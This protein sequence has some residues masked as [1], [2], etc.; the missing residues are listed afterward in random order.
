MNDIVRIYMGQ[1]GASL[2]LSAALVARPSAAGNHIGCFKP[3]LQ[4]SNKDI[5]NGTST[6]FK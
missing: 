2:H 1:L 3:C 4:R 5:A 6:K